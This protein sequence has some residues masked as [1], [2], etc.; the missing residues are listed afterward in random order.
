MSTRIPWAIN[1]DGTPGEVW[2]LWTGCTK[3]SEGCDNCYA[4]KL[5]TGRLKGRFGYPTYDPFRPTYNADRIDQ[6]TKW[7]KP[8]TVFVSSMGDWMHDD[9]TFHSMYHFFKTVH[10]C[11]RHTFLTL[12]K[13]TKNLRIKML[14]YKEWHKTHFLSTPQFFENNLLL[15][16]TIEL[17]KY[18]R[19]L[20]ELFSVF[21]AGYFL[22]LE[23]LLGPVTIPP[24]L[25][26][27]L[28]CVIVGGE[29]GPGARPM[30][31]DWVRSIRDQCDQAGVM[32]FFKGW[33]EWVPVS[34]IKKILDRWWTNKQRKKMNGCT[35]FR[36]GSNESGHKLDGNAYR[37]VPWGPADVWRFHD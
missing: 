32:F 5:A 21:A 2:N 22:S 9:V 24:D 23:P 16:A 36:V 1:P 17:Q 19:R 15:G 4:E 11:P 35:F 31:P 25:L 12:T 18:I 10:R 27:R 30:H 20:D 34:H 7:K 8:R 29:N 14:L 3:F 28:R 37:Q 6:P 13:R 33:G 26:K